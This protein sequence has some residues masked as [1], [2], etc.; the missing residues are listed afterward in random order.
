MYIG[1]DY[2][3]TTLSIVGKGDVEPLLAYHWEAVRGGEWTSRHP[4]Y[5]THRDQRQF[6]APVRFH[7]DDASVKSLNG[8]K[9]LILSLHSDFANGDALFSRLLSALIYD[10]ARTVLK[11]FLENV[12]RDSVTYCEHAKRKT[13]TS[14]DVVY[15]LKRQGRT[16]YGFGG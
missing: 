5:T 3:P 10:E 8:R 7:G 9:M 11:T 2:N 16:L 13:G 1:T 15:A 4:A 6:L 14:L 12:I